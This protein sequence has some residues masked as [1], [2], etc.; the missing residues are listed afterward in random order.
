V[1]VLASLAAVSIENGLLFERTERLATRDS[2]TGLYNRRAFSS[3][4]D[5]RI[6]RSRTFRGELTYILIDVDDFKGVNDAHGHV[7]GDTVLRRVARTLTSCTRDD[8]V[9]G[10]YAGDE[11]V[12][13]LSSDDAASGRSSVARVSAGLRAHGLRCSL[14]AAQFPSDAGD[15]DGLLE[16]ADRALYA[17]KAAGKNGFAFASDF[18]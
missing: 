1:S 12:M 17:A 9:V 18:G 2:L 15:A 14:G 11:F 5:E 8:D 10:R 13:L 7:H 6:A 16:A 3:K 4:L